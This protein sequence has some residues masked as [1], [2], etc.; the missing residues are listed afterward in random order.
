[1]GTPIRTLFAAAV[2]TAALATASTGPATA[3]AAA[4]APHLNTAGVAA[5]TAVAPAPHLNTA[6][7]AAAT[8]FAPAPRPNTAGLAAA[9][10]G[11]AQPEAVPSTPA[12]PTPTNGQAPFPPADFRVT[13]ITPTSVTL[14]WTASHPGSSPVDSYAVNYHQAFNDLYWSQSVGN[15]TTVTI[16]A[17]IRPAHQYS[18][19]VLARGADGRIS[20]SPPAVVVVTPAGTT[21]DTTPPSAPTGLRIAGVTA[22]G[23]ALDWEPSTDNT[24]VAGYD[25][26]F[27]D[28]WF[29]S[30]I[31]GTTTATEF[32]APLT[33]GGTS[34]RAY[35]VRARDAAG[36]VSI[37]SNPVTPTVTTP[38][39]P[40]ARTCRV[41]YTT[42]AEWPGGFAAEVT[43]TNTGPAAVDGW[44]LAFPTG[45]DQRVASS[46]NATFAQSGR[47]V[48]VTAARWNTRIASGGSV[49]AGLLGRWTTSNAAPTAFTLNSAPC[50]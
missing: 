27:F 19:Y 42:T 31:V 10:R 35:Y 44:T 1:M 25:V 30:T 13:G 38:T 49:T 20:T 12:P 8:A 39:P 48:T 32:A 50:D 18:F 7:V 24:A 5:A 45:G 17:S 4:P 37:A 40:P 26:Y 2:T 6:G 15:V 46:W 14:S 9:D 47:N 11:A 33:S 29:T 43:I 22:D 34:L 16:T 23:F 21:G 41:T 28:G 3:T 36:N